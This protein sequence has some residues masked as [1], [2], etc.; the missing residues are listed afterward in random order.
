[1]ADE[2]KDVVLLELT[3]ELALI[4][5]YNL[6]QLED[7]VVKGGFTVPFLNHSQSFAVMM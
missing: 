5:D 1:M 3:A 6:T 4:E 7:Y 2:L